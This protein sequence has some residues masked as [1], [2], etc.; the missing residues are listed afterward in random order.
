MSTPA[1]GSIEQMLVS[2]TEMP[3]SA[4]DFFG[5]GMGG[6]YPQRLIATGR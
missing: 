4:T 1:S 3:E 6:P 5:P 2:A